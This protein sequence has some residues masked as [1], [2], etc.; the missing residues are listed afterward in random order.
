MS[1]LLCVHG[2]THPSRCTQSHP[3]CKTGVSAIATRQY[4]SIGECYSSNNTSTAA[5]AA[6]VPHK[7]QCLSKDK[8]RQNS[9]CTK[10]EGRGRNSGCQRRGQ[11]HGTRERGCHN[12]IA[13]DEHAQRGCAQNVD[14]RCS[15][16]VA[17]VGDAQSLAFLHGA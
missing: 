3:T 5:S 13:H 11:V 8:H 15:E 17:Q 12:N 16:I 4:V 6:A 2:C 7:R 14:E 1:A 10:I 9:C